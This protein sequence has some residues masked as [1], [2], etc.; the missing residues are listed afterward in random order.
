[1]ICTHIKQNKIDHSFCLVLSFEGL[2]DWLMNL[3]IAFSENE[4]S[5]FFIGEDL[6]NS[7]AELW[8]LLFSDEQ[9]PTKFFKPIYGNR[10]PFYITE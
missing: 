3:L 10:D 2:G 4:Y 6:H 9:F 8:P 1:M 7:I 5:S